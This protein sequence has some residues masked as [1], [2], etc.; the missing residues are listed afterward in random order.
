MSAAQH[1]I[2]A[3]RRPGQ[4]HPA[5]NHA[6]IDHAPGEDCTGYLARSCR[7]LADKLMTANSQ[8]ARA[9]EIRTLR[10][11]AEEL[12]NSW[13]TGSRTPDQII[14]D[15]IAWCQAQVRLLEETQP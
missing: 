2:D 12:F 1:S 14:G 6:P 11:C 5:C 8:E 15:M 13:N 3:R 10:R 9:A 7:E 4:H